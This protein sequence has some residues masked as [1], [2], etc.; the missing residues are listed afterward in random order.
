MASYGVDFSDELRAFAVPVAVI[1]GDV[2]ASAPL[3][4]TGARVAELVPTAELTVVVGAGHGLYAA[5]H[6]VVNERLLTFL[7]EDG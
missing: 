2:D 4:H 5:D 6:T 7:A 3:E 1:H